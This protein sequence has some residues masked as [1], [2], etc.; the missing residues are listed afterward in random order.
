M[1]TYDP[2]SNFHAGAI[3][4]GSSMY[5]LPPADPFQRTDPMVMGSANTEQKDVELSDK[6][7][8]KAEDEDDGADALE[9]DGDDEYDS[10]GKRKKRKRRVLFTKGQTYELERRFRTQRF[11]TV[12]TNFSK[13]VSLKHNILS[14]TGCQLF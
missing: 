1:Y 14:H 10:N 12:R 6:N 2:S 7:G 9:D 5:G 4:S 13:K 11:V 3:T 8:S